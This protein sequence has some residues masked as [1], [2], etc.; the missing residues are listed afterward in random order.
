MASLK[1]LHTLQPEI[2]KVPSFIKSSAT[3][4]EK[5]SQLERDFASTREKAEKEKALSQL[6]ECTFAPNIGNA[7]KFIDPSTYRPIHERV[8][9]LI[10]SESL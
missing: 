3:T 1:T 8:S 5:R 9:S 10:A 7:Q 6:A 4:P 2:H